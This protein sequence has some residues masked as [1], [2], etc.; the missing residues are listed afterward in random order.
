MTTEVNILADFAAELELAR[1]PVK[2]RQ[3]AKLV[4]LDTLG[5][6]LAGSIRPEV[7]ALR[8]R[9]AGTAG[10][11]VLTHPV[12]RADARTAAL[13]NGIAGRA[14][15]L[16]DGM[17]YV[18]SQPSVQIIPALLALAE[19][20]DA[21]GADFLAALIAGYEVNG[22]LSTGFKP[23][24]TA[25]Q[26]GQVSLL[27]AVAAACRLKRFRTAQLRSALHM[28]ANLLMAPSYNG[29]VEGATSLNV[30]GGMS[31]VAA[32]LVPDLVEAGFTNQQGAVEEALG[33]LVGDGFEPA[34]ILEGLGSRWEI[35]RNYFRMHACCNPIHPA[36]DAL[37]QAMPRLSVP[38]QEIRAI[39]FET[40]RFA[41]IM[42]NPAPQNFLASKYSL[43]H[44]AATYLVRG[45]TSHRDVDDTALRDPEIVLLRQKVA[46]NDC[47]EMTAA[48]PLEKP[49]RVRVTT[50]DGRVRTAE[51]RSHRGDFSDPYPESA[52]RLKFRDLAGTILPGRLDAIEKAVDDLDS[53]S[54]MRKLLDLV[55]TAS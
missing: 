49:A 14:I 44:V 50:K 45:G 1:V 43:P 41:S 33:Q 15:E 24:P 10:A 21:S 27:G 32:V 28:G 11:L 31:N 6:I 55:A 29:V 7:R 46:I 9:L 16:C 26:N 48:T 30:A 23:R 2:A 17:R 38:P 36:L 34:H 35:T 42:R 37:E 51:V 3:W 39:E 25:H 18:S 8:G 54:S 12:A 4:V 22:R 53:L 19:L 40:F 52:I 47:V 13:L 5:V 20:G